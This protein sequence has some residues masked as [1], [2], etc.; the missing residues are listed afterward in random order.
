[1]YSGPRRRR[2]RSDPHE[3]AVRECD[4]AERRGDRHRRRLQ[5]GAGPAGGDAASRAGAEV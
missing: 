4:A 2:I 3:R 1:M 5:R